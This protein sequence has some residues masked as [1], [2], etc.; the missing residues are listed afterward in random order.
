M[1]VLRKTL[2]NLLNKE[3]IQASNFSVEVLIIFIKK[4]DEE[5]RFCV[6]YRELNAITQ[7]DK[8]SLSLIN[9]TLRIIASVK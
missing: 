5:L 8:Y 4:L 7:R 6:N 2:L 1:L 9:K 3:F